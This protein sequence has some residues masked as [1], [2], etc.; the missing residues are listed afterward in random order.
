M[1]QGRG[2]GLTAASVR[3]LGIAKT[4]TDLEEAGETCPVAICK[5]IILDRANRTNNLTVECTLL[6]RGWQGFYCDWSR[7]HAVESTGCGQW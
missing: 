6:A 1:E 7:F 2:E 4:Q 3:F 5:P